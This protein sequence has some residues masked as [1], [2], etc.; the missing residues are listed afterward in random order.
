MRRRIIVYILAYTCTF[1]INLHK[2]IYCHVYKINKLMS[3][4]RRGQLIWKQLVDSDT[5][6]ENCLL[7]SAALC[8]MYI[9]QGDNVKSLIIGRVQEHLNRKVDVT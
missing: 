4:K 8:Q 5:I 3:K 1:V 7:S 2:F 9:V 6:I